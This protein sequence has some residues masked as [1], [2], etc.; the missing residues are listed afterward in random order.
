MTEARTLAAQLA[1]Q[2]ADR[3]ALHHQRDQQRAWRCRLPRRAQYEAT[4]FGL[5]ASTDDMREGTAAFLEKRKPE[6]KGK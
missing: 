5:V 4:L 2:R 6:F 3:H 1:A